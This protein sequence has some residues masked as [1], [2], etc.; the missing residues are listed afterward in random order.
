[1]SELNLDQLKTKIA[2]AK[3]VLVLLPPQPDADQIRAGLSIHAALK[4]ATKNVVIG[5]SSKVDSIP[6]SE[7][8]ETTVGKQNLIIS[9]PY[10]EEAV[11][12]VSYD[13]DE[14][15]NRFNLVIRPKENAQPLDAKSVNFSYTGAS[16]DLVITVGISSLEELGKLYSDEKQF[17]DQATVCNVKKGGQPADFAA[18]D[19]SGVRVSSWAELVAYFIKSSDLKLTAESASDL[20]R[21]L[22]SATNNFQSPLITAETFETAAF[23]L[24]SGA[25]TFQPPVAPIDSAKLPPAPFFPSPAVAPARPQQLDRRPQPQSAKKFS[26]SENGQKSNVPADWQ[27]PKIYRGSQETPSMVK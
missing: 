13:I 25:R 3:S 26:S 9:F 20:Y 7:L 1:M 6:G 4:N 2:Q 17:L 19:L 8:I 22:L 15:T 23:L 27:R 21:Q 24:R 18:F 12:H 5:C 16:A 11:E 10:K 14:A